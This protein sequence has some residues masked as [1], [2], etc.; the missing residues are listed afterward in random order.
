MTC[1]KWAEGCENVTRKPLNR[2]EIFMQKYYYDNIKIGGNIRDL[3]I[4]HEKSQAQLAM[5]L[6]VSSKT[7]HNWERGNKGFSIEHLIALSNYFGV[8]TD[9][10]LGLTA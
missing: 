6:G 7:I 10:I 3:R 9:K 5:R 1:T 8:T 2:K 4:K